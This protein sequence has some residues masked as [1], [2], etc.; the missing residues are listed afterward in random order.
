[1]RL[2]K[3]RQDFI[4]GLESSDSRTDSFDGAGAIG[5]GD[6][7]VLSWEGVFTLFGVY[8]LNKLA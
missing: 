8:Q 5:A 2:V 4:A 1:M 3:E 6:Y 7:V